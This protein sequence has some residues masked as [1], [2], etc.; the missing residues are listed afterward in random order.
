MKS[1]DENI[2]IIKFEKS[3]NHPKQSIEPHSRIFLKLPKNCSGSD[4]CKKKFRF[5]DHEKENQPHFHGS[6]IYFQD[7]LWCYQRVIT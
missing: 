4:D 7:S 5:R 3:L 2:Y 6:K 1:S